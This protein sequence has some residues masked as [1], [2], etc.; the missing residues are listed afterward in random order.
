MKLIFDFDSC[1]N[2]K[3][4]IKDFIFDILN[5]LRLKIMTFRKLSK[6]DFG[7]TLHARDDRGGPG[8]RIL[9]AAFINLIYV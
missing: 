8:R 6:K 3:L 4:K 5:D 1:T 7:L 9:M 2:F